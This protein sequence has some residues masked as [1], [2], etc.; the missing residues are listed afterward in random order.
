MND[1]LYSTR[2][3]PTRS[4][5]SRSERLGLFLLLALGVLLMLIASN[6][7]GG[8]MPFTATRADRF[9]TT[10]TPRTSIRIDNVSGDIV[11]A[12]GKSFAV[13]V[14]VTVSAPTQKR[15]DEVLARTVIWQAQEDDVYALE[16]RWPNSRLHWDSHNRRS[17]QAWCEDCRITAKYDVTLPAGV[18]AR[19]ATVNGEVSVRDVD[20]ELDL[21]S[22]NG[23]V[24]AEG[25]RRSVRAHTVN[26]KVEAT[27]AQLPTGAS[28]DCRTVNGAVTLTFPRDAKFELQASVMSGAI[29]STFALPSHAEPDASP[30]L[31]EPPK[32]KDK[33]REKDKIKDVERERRRVYVGED[34]D[35]VE[36]DLSEIERE[37]EREMR[38][39]QIE[40]RRAQREMERSAAVLALPIG[41]SYTGSI[42]QGGASV[43]VSTLNGAVTVLAAGTRESDAKPLVSPRRMVSITIPPMVV[44]APRIA[45]V[46]PVPPSAPVAPVAAQPA[47]A[48]RPHPHPHTPLPPGEE[49]TIVRG[50]ISGDFLSTRTSASY[51]V[52]KVTGRVRI[53]TNLGEIHVASVG[54][55]AD[56][57]T[58]GGDIV[59]GPVGGEFRALTMA[60]DVKAG[61]VGGAATCETSGGDIRIDSVKGALEAR[62]AGGDVVVRS[63]G[64]AA[65]IETGGGEVRIAL[66]SRQS[67]VSVRNAGGDVTVTLPADFRGEF[68]LQ[69]DG[70][71]PDEAAIRSDF[72]QIAVVKREDRQ[73]ASGTVNGGGARVVVRTSSGKIRIRKG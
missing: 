29:S 20:A 58:Y 4:N 66:T 55:T 69:V 57:K 22:V 16:T 49:E 46:A 59:T 18:P 73:Q 34:G 63:I 68:D 65:D 19:L 36:V 42:G 56:L 9:T 12:P 28:W 53:L 31:A 67:A 40:M 47:P 1:M 15:A 8:E 37:V 30:A 2:P 70:A 11:V 21:S 25:A 5:S 7:R 17:P 33:A 38:E 39:V 3:E 43:K 64:G 60:G 44:V 61:A 62:T 14:T 10:V 27:A 52:G 45:P 71:S 54:G 41:R 32:S 23:N 24:R 26:G 48:P 50:D 51:E 72:P 35:E 6:S 13:T